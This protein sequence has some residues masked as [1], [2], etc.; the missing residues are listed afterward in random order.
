MA[1][2]LLKVFYIGR[3]PIKEDNV[4][5]SGH[6]WVGYGDVVEMPRQKAAI[7]LINHPDVWVGEK[8]FNERQENESV[9]QAHAAKVNSEQTKE[10]EKVVDED[11][12][13]L[14]NA[15][16]TDDDKEKSEAPLTIYE[17]LIK[18]KA[19]AELTSDLKAKYFSAKTGNPKIDAVREL[20][21]SE[22]TT[23]EVKE[24][25]LQIVNAAG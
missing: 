16:K 8:E 4:T 19:G 7:L 18:M 5:H 9:N 14:S 6:V 12:A 21:N 1:E 24:V 23:E 11:D 22:A 20:T 3:K 10:P 13:D 15:D 17:A 25:W 2:D